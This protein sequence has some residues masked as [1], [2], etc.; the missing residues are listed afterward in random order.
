MT[1]LSIT[2]LAYLVFAIVFLIDKYLLVSSIPNPKVYTFY[3]SFFRILVVLLIP[4]VGFYIPSAS[5]LWLSFLA[6]SAFVLAL[7]WFFKGLQSFEPSRIVPAIGGTLPFF[8]FLLV[9]LF[10]QGK[11]TL[12]L[13][14]FA[15]L[16]F[17]VLG[18]FLI[19][20]EKSKRISF[21]S[22]RVSTAAAFFFALSF[23]LGKY[24]YL[25][26]T[27]WNGFILI[28]IGGF[29]ASL[30]FLSAKEVRE[31][32]FKTK[33]KMPKKTAGIFFLNQAMGAGANV[34]QNFALFLAPLTYVA[35]INALQGIQYVFLLILTIILSLKLPQILKEEISKKII[36]QKIIAILLI[37]G[38]LA[39]LT[40]K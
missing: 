35:I 22:W 16:V 17:L 32:L 33:I 1:W 26:Q 30:I 23:V 9:Y 5:Q 24:V 25:A 3:V 31:G 39:I 4:F 14:D 19:T 27:F 13:S 6:G 2:I 7:F 40:L 12:G 38:G 15:A 29:L 34:L 28:S 21:K 8:S 37:G 18:S 20:L 36:F 10:S 11:E